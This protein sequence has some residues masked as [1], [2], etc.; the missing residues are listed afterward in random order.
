[1]RILLACLLAAPLAAQNQ[2]PPP[3][4]GND[5]KLLMRKFYEEVWFG[6]NF[7]F[8]NQVFAPTYKAHDPREKRGPVD[9]KPEAQSQIAAYWHEIADVGGRIEAQMAEGDRVMTQWIWRVRMK[10]AWR[11]MLTGV[12]TFEVPVIQVARFQNGKIVELWNLRDDLAID[13]HLGAF[14]LYY[15]EGFLLGVVAFAIGSRIWRRR[16][17]ESLEQPS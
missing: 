13:E 8:A 16:R 9:E 5:N 6:K 7:S 4:S 1:M 3:V 14:R 10:S 2:T 11:R 17:P 15:L 12:D